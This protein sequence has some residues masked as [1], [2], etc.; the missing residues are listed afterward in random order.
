MCSPLPI[1]ILEM[2]RLVPSGASLFEA[3]SRGKDAHLLNLRSEGRSEM[4]TANNPS[5]FASLPP[6]LLFPDPVLVFQTSP[7]NLPNLC[8]TPLTL[9]R[10]LP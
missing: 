8:L 3:L 5:P 6:S 7:N 1:E 10:T 9:S 4:V 2:G